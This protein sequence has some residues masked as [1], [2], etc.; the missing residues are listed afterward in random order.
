VGRASQTAKCKYQKAKC[1]EDG[2]WSHENTKNTKAGTDARDASDAQVKLQNANIKRQNASAT[3]GSAGRT[4]KDAKSAKDGRVEPQMSTVHAAD[5]QVK[6]QSASIKRQNALAA[7]DSGGGTGEDAKDD[8]LSQ[9]TEAGGQ[10]PAGL[11]SRY[12]AT[13]AATLKTSVR[14]AAS[15][16]SVR[17]RAFHFAMSVA[18]SI[19]SDSP[20]MSLRVSAHISRP[21]LR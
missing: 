11:P 7:Q 6:L 16:A 15:K 14:M 4:A 13:G 5:A 10:G 19:A 9:I 8:Q 20:E 12:G 17:P 18:A 1:F 21:K 3:K 2:M